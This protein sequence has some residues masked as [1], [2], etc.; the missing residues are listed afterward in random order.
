M[1]YFGVFMIIFSICLFFTGLYAY[2]GHKI[3]LFSFRVAFRN[4]TIKGWKNI[5]KWVIIVSI[6]V[7]ILGL[8][9]MLIN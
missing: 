4:L 1:F 9:L 6:F 2:T 7:F 3:G 5:G 8:L